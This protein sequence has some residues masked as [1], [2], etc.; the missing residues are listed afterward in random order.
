MLDNISQPNKGNKM[1]QIDKEKSR[2][3]LREFFYQ[4]GGQVK[5]ANR[6]G[7]TQGAVSGWLRRGIVPIKAIPLMCALLGVKASELRPDVY[8]D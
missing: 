5:V 2:A 3:H 7:I 8:F 6:Y 4:M 1:Q